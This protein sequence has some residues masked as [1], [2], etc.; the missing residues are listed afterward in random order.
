ML[1]TRSTDISLAYGRMVEDRIQWGFQ[2]TLLTFMF[3]HISHS[4]ARARA[5]MIGEVERVYAKLLT[6]VIRRPRKMR[7][8]ALPFWLVSPDWPV[9]KSQSRDNLRDLTAN[10]GQHLHAVALTPP[11]G[12]LQGSLS[13]HLCFNHDIYYPAGCVLDRIHAVPITKTPTKATRYVLKSLERARVD[14][15]DVVVLPRCHSEL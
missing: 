2:P 9:P 3:N 4:S 14:P 5:V 12:R 10:G 6:R 8:I 13:D 11:G 7:I 15:G 1:Q